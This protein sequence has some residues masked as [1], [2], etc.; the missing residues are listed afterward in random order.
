MPFDISKAVPWDAN[1]VSDYTVAKR[2]ANI[3]DVEPSLRSQIKD[4]ARHYNLESIKFC[5]RG[6]RWDEENVDMTGDFW[7]AAYLPVWLFTYLDKKDS[8]QTLHYIAVNAQ[9]R[10]TMGSIPYSKKGVDIIYFI[11][12]ALLLALLFTPL[13]VFIPVLLIIWAVSYFT[14]GEKYRNAY[15]RHKHEKETKYTVD[16]M[17]TTDTFVKEHYKLELNK[18]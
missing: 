3:N 18:K 16:N 14:I 2:D 8:N 9:T 7:Q 15:A 12:L 10:E 1:Y 13:G 5:D 4:I 17:S 6:V 11:I